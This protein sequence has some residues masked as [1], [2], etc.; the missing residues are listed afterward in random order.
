VTFDVR[1][2]SQAIGYAARAHGAQTRKGTDV[3]YL[4]HLLAVTALTMEHGGSTEQCQAAALHDVV[5]DHGGAERLAEVRRL[6]GDAVA[7]MVGAL[8][9]AVPTRGEA[10][11]PWEDRK[12]TYLAHLAGLAATGDPA[13]L[14]SACDKLHN[15]ESIVADATDPDG[16]PGLAVFDR[17]SAPPK[18]VACY[19]RGLA[20]ALAGADL[21]ERLHVRLTN[22]VER[23]VLLAEQAAGRDG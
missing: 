6:F 23:L 11:P 9:D 19:Y 5:E 18:Q 22:A 21:P 3:P 4:S 13:V 14:V 7:D 20:D 15:A 8:S 16:A 2:V 1:A 12:Q 10:K 17:F